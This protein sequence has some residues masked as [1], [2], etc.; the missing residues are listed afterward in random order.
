[1]QPFTVK[2][3]VRNRGDYLSARCVDVPGLHVYGKDLPSVR[4]T[5]IKAVKQLFKANK[6]L[7]VEVSP[8]DDLTELRIRPV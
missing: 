3:D 7:D 4:G 1:M 8:T 6:G 2:L 5:A